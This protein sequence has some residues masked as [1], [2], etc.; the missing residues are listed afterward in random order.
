MTIQSAAKAHN[1]YLEVYLDLGI[2]GL[3]LLCGF[4]FQFCVKIR[5]SIESNPEWSMLAISLVTMS[6]L[7]NYTESSFLQANN[8]LW[9]VTV[10]LFVLLR[11]ASVPK[12]NTGRYLQ[13]SHAS[14]L[15]DTKEL[16]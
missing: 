14:H 1:G 7:Y 3:L 13:E 15:D 9:S 2:A 6:L 5:R 16:I 12:R 8:Y 11:W 4:L 10:F